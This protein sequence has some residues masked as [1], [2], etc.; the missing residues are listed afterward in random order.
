MMSVLK[1]EGHKIEGITYISNHDNALNDYN[2]IK[3]IGEGTFGK[4]FLA[5]HIKIKETVAIKTI[6]KQMLLGKDDFNNINREIKFL[7]RLKRDPNIIKLYQAIETP[8]CI[9][10]VTEVAKGGEL[11]NY[12][13]KKSKLDETEA[14]CI[15]NQI[16]LSVESIHNFNII[17][18]DIKPENI[19]LSEDCKLIKICDFGLSNNCYK[20]DLLSTP[21]GSPCYAPPE[22]ILNRKYNKSVDIWSCGIT[23]FTMLCGC[24]PFEDPNTD[25][26]YKKILSCDIN[27]PNHLSINAKDMLKKLLTVTPEKRITIQEIKKHPFFKSA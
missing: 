16:I 10:L 11:F 18:R 6:Q 19:L 4:V 8:S 13:T 15:F 3:S 26:L 17:H 20:G 12:I 23:L 1:K 22:M 27:F 2:I 7:K 24:L 25:K 9:Y 5:E 21:C 14:A